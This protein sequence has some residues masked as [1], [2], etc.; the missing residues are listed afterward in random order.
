M[1]KTQFKLLNGGLK[2]CMWLDEHPNAHIIS[3]TQ[4]NTS[5]TI[6]YREYADEDYEREIALAIHNSYPNF[7]ISSNDIMQ[8]IE[9]TPNTH[10]NAIPRPAFLC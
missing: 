6:F 2:V 9:S 5:Y 10:K 3:I 4:S 8:Y 7:A 1:E